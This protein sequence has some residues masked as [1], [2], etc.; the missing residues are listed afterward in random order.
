ME[1]YSQIEI[2]NCSFIPDYSLVGVTPPPIPDALTGYRV[3]RVLAYVQQTT[4]PKDGPNERPMPV[5]L[6][7]LA[8]SLVYSAR[9]VDVENQIVGRPPFFLK[10]SGN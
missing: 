1:S 7:T 4:I 2:K 5:E 8:K 3:L 6:I 9:S 10:Y